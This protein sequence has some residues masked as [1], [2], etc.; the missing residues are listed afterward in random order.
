MDLS[1]PIEI[2]VGGVVYEVL[3]ILQ[4][5]EISVF[6]NVVVERA[7]MLCAELDKKLGEHFLE[8][9]EDIPQSL[10]GARL[11]FAEVT[12][13]RSGYKSAL[14]ISYSRTGNGWVQNWRWFG[15]DFGYDCFLLRRKAAT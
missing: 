8:H 11:V 14:M 4:D 2:T 1:I 5:G 13:N 12:H 9:Q 10:Q 15:E 3:P 7:A 6:G